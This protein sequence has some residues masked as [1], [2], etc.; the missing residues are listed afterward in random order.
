MISTEMTRTGPVRD[1]KE[2]LR[3]DYSRIQKSVNPELYQKVPA[4]DKFWSFVANILT[5][6]FRKM[7]FKEISKL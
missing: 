2:G 6:V 3:A 5:K 1:R 4:N 7:Y